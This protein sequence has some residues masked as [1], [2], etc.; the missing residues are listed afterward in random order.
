MLVVD[1]SRLKG[2]NE[3]SRGKMERGKEKTKSEERRER[4]WEGKYER[5]W[6]K[7][8]GEEFKKRKISTK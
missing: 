1:G 6:N 3:G 5:G 2:G 8:L 7:I 4:D